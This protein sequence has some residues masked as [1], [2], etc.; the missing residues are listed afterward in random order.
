MKLIVQSTDL[1]RYLESSEV[2]DFSDFKIK[3]MAHKIVYR[4]EN[5]IEVTKKIYDFVR[6]EI[7]HSC[8][9]GKNRVNW[10]ASDVLKYKHGLCFGKSHL[11][12]ALLRTMDIP[13]GFCYQ[14]IKFED[15]M[16][17]HGLNGVFIKSINN[18]IRL[19]ARGNKKGI[20]AGFNIK[21]ENLAYVPDKAKGEFDLPT[22]YTRPN[23]RI[24][25]I[26][27]NSPN[28]KEAMDK[29]FTRV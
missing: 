13:A 10:K 19:D 3:D 1:S 24:I 7:E 23:E 29:I 16:G 12:A 17:L 27:K 11:L 2:I 21:R 14:K 5:E 25:K 9:A 26:L 6:D 4:A 18:W 20:N 8:D 22:I 15:K 28:L